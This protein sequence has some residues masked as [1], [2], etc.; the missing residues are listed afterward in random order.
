MT[1][2]NHFDFPPRYSGNPLGNYLRMRRDPVSL[3]TEAFSLGDMVRVRIAYKDFLLV[4][5][6]R[7]FRRI[8]VEDSSNFPREG[9]S[10]KNLRPYIG[11][12]AL[13]VNGPAWEQQRRAMRAVITDGSAEMT[14]I[15][16]AGASQ[17]I[18]RW[19]SAGESSIDAARETMALTYSIAAEAYLGYRPDDRRADEFAQAFRQPKRASFATGSVA[20]R[21]G[22]TCRRR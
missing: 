12:N 15:V 2:I 4:R 16:L 1:P 13:T 19:T 18:E 10:V 9:D 5:S 20:C 7:A 3:F 6:P 21:C 8:L 11:E 14:R 22:S 17:M